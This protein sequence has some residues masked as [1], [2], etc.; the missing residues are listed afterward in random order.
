MRSTS[1]P[2]LVAAI[3]V[4]LLVL[5]HKADW[6]WEETI[7]PASQRNEGPGAEIDR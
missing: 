7:K 6:T 1:S 3:Y 5:R 4:V 2:K